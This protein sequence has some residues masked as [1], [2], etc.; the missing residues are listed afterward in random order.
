MNLPDLSHMM[1][2]GQLRYIQSVYET[3]ECRNP[4]VLV[5][6]LLS[7]LERW[8]SDLRGRTSL[9]KL[10]ANPFYYYVLARTRYYDAVY[11]DTVCSNLSY[12]LNIGCGSD[13]RAYRFGHILKQ[14]NVGI[15]EF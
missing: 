15:V 10:R 4:D 14:R 8:R 6:H 12:V 3:P 13:T 2:V 9:T 11:I 5:K 1:K 7:R